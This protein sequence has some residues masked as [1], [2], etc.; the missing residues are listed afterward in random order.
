MTKKSKESMSPKKKGRDYEEMFP[1]YE[2][3]KTPD[4]IYDYPKTPKEV[5]DV[6][7]EIGKPSLE[8]LVE[9]LVLF[10]KYKKE[11]KKKPGHYIQGNIALGAAEKEFIPSKGE[12]LASELGKMIRSILQHHSKK[13]IDQWKKKEKI[14]S[15]KITFT[16]ITF[17]HFDVMGS[18]RFFY[19]EKK[20]EKITLSF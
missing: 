20:P 10:K 4:T 7:S 8:K 19:A 16:E 1:D 6:L 2:P 18:G 3:K 14:S 12:L 11:A 9:I 5:V 13:E 17:I 15:Q